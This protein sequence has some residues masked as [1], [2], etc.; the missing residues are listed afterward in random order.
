M[1]ILKTT[2]GKILV[3]LIVATMLFIFIQS[4]IPSEE[5]KKESDA[6][7]EI[8]EEVVEVIVPDNPSF[9]DLVK[10]NI[11][12]IAHFVEFGALGLECGILL[13]LSFVSLKKSKDS[14][15]KPAAVRYLISYSA[16]FCGFGLLVGLL[17]ESIQTL[18][19]RG[20]SISDV[21]LDFLGFLSFFSVFMLVSL[22]IMAL[23]RLRS[24]QKK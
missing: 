4:A 23:R 15:G 16:A 17:D 5:S 3:C 21:W 18:S 13:L 1:G 20:P 24:S 6:V 7:G 10:K 2:Y 11:R 8:V 12:K 22:G 19:D 14:L 9:A